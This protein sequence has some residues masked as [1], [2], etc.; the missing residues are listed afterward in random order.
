[1]AR[2]LMMDS[3]CKIRRRLNARLVKAHEKGRLAEEL[4]VIER[5]AKKWMSN[6]HAASRKGAKRA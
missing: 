1:M 6:G 5:E 2:D 3:C 4:G